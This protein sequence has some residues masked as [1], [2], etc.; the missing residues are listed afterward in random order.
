MGWVILRLKENDSNFLCFSDCPAER[1]KENLIELCNGAWVEGRDETDK[2][3][4]AVVMNIT[5]EVSK[6]LM[7]SHSSSVIDNVLT[8][9]RHTHHGIN[10]SSIAGE[11]TCIVKVSDSAKCFQL[12]YAHEIAK[13]VQTAAHMHALAV[14]MTN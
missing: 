11:G 5:K 4:L 12:S 10:D 3:S 9:A 7:H 1:S 2:I 13:P 8:N 14:C 6:G